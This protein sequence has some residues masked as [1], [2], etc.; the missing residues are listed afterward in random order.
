MGALGMYYLHERYRQS[1]PR[2]DSFALSGSD[3]GGSAG[4][5]TLFVTSS[6]RGAVIYIDG[7][8]SGQTNAYSSE[9]CGWNPQC[10]R[11][12]TGIPDGDETGQCADWREIFGF[13]HAPTRRGYGNWHRY[14][15]PHIDS[16]VC[17]DLHRR[18]R[19]G[20]T[21]TSIPDVAA[22]IRNVTVTKP[23]YQTATA[24][25]SVQAGESKSVSFT[26]QHGVDSG[27]GTR[28]TLLVT[29]SPRSAVIYIDGIASGQ[30]NAYSSERCGWNP[31]CH[32]RETGLPDCH[33]T[34]QCEGR[35]ENYR[36]IYP[37]TRRGCRNWH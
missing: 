9:H 6:P 31:Q 28:V 35:R 4:T 20:Q 19:H 37:P 23:G 24:L 10:H 34:G 16:R 29:S 32:S 30:T 26:L 7:I 2:R 27:T 36:F 13:L 22:G 18:H 25:I 15:P 1:Y 5:G 12:K 14:P 8:A 17:S 3:G 11:H 33:G 21:N